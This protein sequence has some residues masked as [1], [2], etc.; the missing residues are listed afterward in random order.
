MSEVFFL[1]NIFKNRQQN[2]SEFLSSKNHFFFN[3]KNKSDFFIKKKRF[4]PYI[5]LCDL[6]FHSHVQHIMHDM[7][8]IVHWS[9]ESRR[10]N[11][12][13]AEWVP[14]TLPFSSLASGFRFLVQQI[15]PYLHLFW[16]EC[17]QDNRSCKYLVGCNQDPK[18]CNFLFYFIIFFSDM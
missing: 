1:E 2:R 8:N 4:H 18:L 12:V 17:N 7:H 9:Q 14:N 11:F 15:Q 5:N 3:N 6:I 10:P 13:W 16:V